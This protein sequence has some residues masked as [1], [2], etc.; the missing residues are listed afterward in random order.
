LTPLRLRRRKGKQLLFPVQCAAR[1]LCRAGRL[2]MRPNTRGAETTCSLNRP[3]DS[4]NL[5]S[6]NQNY[7]RLVNAFCWLHSNFLMKMAS[8]CG[9]LMQ[10]RSGPPL[11]SRTMKLPPS[12]E[13]Q[14]GI[15]RPLHCYRAVLLITVDANIQ[16]PISGRPTGKRTKVRH[17]L[18]PHRYAVFHLD[19]RFPREASNTS[20]HFL[21]GLGCVSHRRF[22]HPLAIKDQ[23]LLQ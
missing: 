4:V 5:R 21:E 20:P 14:T 6:R 8:P 7:V 18:C 16:D 11:A 23:G 9:M 2:A 10:S 22:G 15:G 19:P 12:S 17:G 3:T 1:C 13:S